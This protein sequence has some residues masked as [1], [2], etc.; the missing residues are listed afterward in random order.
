MSNIV[1]SDTN[2]AARRVDWE[3]TTAGLGLPKTLTAA[4]VVTSNVIQPKAPKAVK[5]LLRVGLTSGGVTVAMCRHNGT[6]NFTP[7]TDCVAFDSTLLVGAHAGHFDGLELDTTDAL[8][9]ISVQA[10]DDGTGASIHDAAL[11]LQELFP[12]GGGYHEATAAFNGLTYDGGT[13]VAPYSDV[14]A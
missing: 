1:I 4:Q 12:A 9:F 3:S 5:A 11:Y 13:N 7:G 2:L 8:P 6:P 10:T 14:L